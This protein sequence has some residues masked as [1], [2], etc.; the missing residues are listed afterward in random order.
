VIQPQAQ[1]PDHTRLVDLSSDPGGGLSEESRERMREA[2]R[3]AALAELAAEAQAW[4]CYDEPHPSYRP[5]DREALTLNMPLLKQAWPYIRAATLRAAGLGAKRNPPHA[6]ADRSRPA[7]DG[8]A[9]KP[10]CSE[11][12][13]GIPDIIGSPS[14][15]VKRRLFGAAGTLRLWEGRP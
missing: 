14:P 13:G 6:L 3:Q 5:I 8:P 2:G 15:S 11:R 12:G 4:G 7:S 10:R 1:Q 9:T